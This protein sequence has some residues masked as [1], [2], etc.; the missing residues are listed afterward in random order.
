MQNR[1]CHTGIADWSDCKRCRLHATRRRVALRRDSPN[2][3]QRIHLGIIGEA[4]GETE[5]VLGIPFTGISGRI[6]DTMLSYVSYQFSYVITNIVA[7]RPMTIITVGEVSELDTL[8]EDEDEYEII[9]KNREPNA[10]EIEAC[11]PHID[12]IVQS[13]DF[14]GIVY[15]GKVA[16]KYKTKLPSVELFH[17]AYIARMEYKYLTVLRQARK[18]SKF[19]ERLQNE[20]SV[21]NHKRS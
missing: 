1:T 4:P 10:A 19:I 11:K 6:L 3:R 8:P 17:P 9:D 7:C 18:L 16:A 2:G 12:E 21:S 15:L 13:E 20:G 5:D 14:D